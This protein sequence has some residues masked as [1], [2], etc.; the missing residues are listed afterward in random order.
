MEMIKSIIPHQLQKDIFGFVKLRENSKAPFELNWPNKPYSYKDIQSWIDQG[1]NYGVL[2]GHGGLVI[3]D[4]DT[5]EL[6]HIIQEK[7]TATFTVKSSRTGYH[8]YFM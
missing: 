6:S 3:V 2:G 4:A 8:H 5:I 7:L 1:N